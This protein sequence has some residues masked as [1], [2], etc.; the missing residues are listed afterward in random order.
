M[1]CVQV[2]G[3]DAAVAFAGSQGN[4]QLNVYKP[5]MIHNLMHSIRLLSDASLSFND[6]CAIGIEPNVERIKQNLVESLMLVTS[7]NSHIGY[8][9]AAKVA[10]KAYNENITLKDATLALGLLTG[11]EFDDFVRP[12]NMVGPS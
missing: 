5:V 10:K 6:N 8:D 4:F 3:N 11:E 2:L 12:E 1:V 7:L 9:D